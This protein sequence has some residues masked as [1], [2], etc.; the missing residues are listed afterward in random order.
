MF[1]SLLFDVW[2]NQRTRAFAIEEVPIPPP[3]AVVYSYFA[4]ERMEE[5]QWCT[6]E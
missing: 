2:T 4:C 3:A 5:R 6:M 1:C